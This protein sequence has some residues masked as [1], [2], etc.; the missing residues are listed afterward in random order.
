MPTGRRPLNRARD[1]RVRITRE[2]GLLYV[3][4]VE[5][6]RTGKHEKLE[7][8]GGKRRE[9]LDVRS[10]LHR[11]LDR[12]PWQRNVLDP[13]VPIDGES[14]A[15]RRDM[16]AAIAARRILDRYLPR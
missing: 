5:I 15:A 1:G 4:A 12:R 6:Q 13:L 2:M 3:R 8:E 14:D 9:Y 10:A 11:A 7:H 16:Q